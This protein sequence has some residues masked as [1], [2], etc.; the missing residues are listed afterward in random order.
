MS[1]AA[2]CPTSLSDLI[3]FLRHAGVVDLLEY[4]RSDAAPCLHDGLAGGGVHK[5]VEQLVPAQTLGLDRRLPPVIRPGVHHLGVEVLEDLFRIHGKR[6]QQHRYRQLAAP[7]DAHEDQ[8]LGIELEVEPRAPVGNDPRGI[9]ILARAVRLAPVM[10][11]EDAGRA[12]HLGD[13]DPLGAVDDE[14]AAVSHQRHVAH[15]DVLLLDVPHRAEPAVLVDVPDHEPERHLERSRVG[16]A[17]LLAFLDVVF[18]LL[19]LVA[20]EIQRCL[21][22]EVLDREHRLEDSLKPGLGALISLNFALQ[23]ELVGAPLHLDEVR[24]RGNLRNAA[25][26]PT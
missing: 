21:V 26:T 19:E 11:E 6:A 17:A 16:D 23:E 10:V 12:M 18:R 13:D 3:S 15:V 22:G 5:V 9:E 1:S 14:G 7:V 20:F 24:H 8:V 25:E 4:P 2:Y